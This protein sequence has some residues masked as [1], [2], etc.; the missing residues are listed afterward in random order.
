MET[1]L[2]EGQFEDQMEKTSPMTDAHPEGF[3]EEQR[4]A[5][6]MKEDVYPEGPAIEEVPETS[7]KD[8][9]D[10]RQA[11]AD[12][13]M[14]DP[15]A[16][17]E[18]CLALV[19]V[20]MPIDT[21]AETQQAEVQEDQ[22]EDYEAPVPD[23][24]EE[25][26]DSFSEE[27]PSEEELE[28]PMEEERGEGQASPSAAQPEVGEGKAPTSVPALEPLIEVISPLQAISPEDSPASQEYT[29]DTPE[30]RTPYPEYGSPEYNPGEAPYYPE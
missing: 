7:P 13:S 28:E 20:P 23:A 27:D 29:P 4:E 26:P 22:Y 8:P 10:G 1:S 12:V 17:A 15:A 19:L 3:T 25:S 2:P 11:A 30:P 16:A 21:D 9:A 5:S 14:D 24:R 6:P 18:P